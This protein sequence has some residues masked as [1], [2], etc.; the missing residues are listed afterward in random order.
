MYHFW[1]KDQAP[2]TVIV[3][4]I[5]FVICI[6]TLHPAIAYILYTLHSCSYSFHFTLFSMTIWQFTHWMKCTNVKFCL[7][8]IIVSFFVLRLSS[9]PLYIS[10]FYNKLNVSKFN[11]IKLIKIYHNTISYDHN[12]AIKCM[13]VCMCVSARTRAWNTLLNMVYLYLYFIDCLNILFSL[14]SWFVLLTT[15]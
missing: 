14:G 15:P 3:H 8:F 5:V 9:C 2:F 13:C 4:T 10:S 11:C 6:C 12:T 1:L 7:N